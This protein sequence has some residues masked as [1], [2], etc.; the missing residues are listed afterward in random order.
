MGENLANLMYFLE[1]TINQ[2]KSPNE[3]LLSNQPQEVQ[4]E[5]LEVANSVERLCEVKYG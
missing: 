2:N 3:S 5:W 4:K 1:M